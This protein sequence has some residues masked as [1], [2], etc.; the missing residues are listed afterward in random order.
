VGDQSQVTRRE[1]TYRDDELARA[2]AASHSWRAVLRVLGLAGTSGSVIR[3][4]RH[5]A[6]RL[7]LDYTHFTGGRHWTDAGLTRAVAGSRSWSEVE[8]TLGLAGG[9]SRRTLK[10]HA[11]RLGLDDVHLRSVARDSVSELEWPDP[12][13]QF[14]SRAGS[15]LAAAWFA[16]R[17]WEVAWPLEPCRYDL[18][19]TKQ[20]RVLRV[21]VKTTTVQ[22][23]DT[24]TVWLSKA[25]KV[26]VTYD[27]D[28]ID[29]FF[30][31]DGCLRYC[32]LPLR[33]VGGLHQIHLSAYSEYRVDGQYDACV[34]AV[35]C[36][37][38][39]GQGNVA[40]C[41]RP[42]CTSTSTPSARSRG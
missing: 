41:A 5:H 19:V 3:S 26:R 33:A 9:S 12:D 42:T 2:V 11:E 6:D 4:V 14:L 36:A 20:R 27:S 39:G 18:L 1:R 35:P 37:A 10:G 21:Q 40:G 24:W 23:G 16:L 32:L 34:A 29:Y 17:G 15:H 28:E 25:R 31:V 7:G 38:G 22:V 13:P 8:Q 30:V